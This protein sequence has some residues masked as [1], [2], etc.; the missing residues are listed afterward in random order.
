NLNKHDG[1]LNFC[2]LKKTQDKEEYKPRIDKIALDI[3]LKILFATNEGDLLGRQFYD[4]LSKY[5]GYITKL[6]SHRQ[7]Q[8]LPIRCMEYDLL[9]SNTRDYIKNE[10]HR[11]INRIVE[12]YSPRTIVV[13][14]LSF[15]SMNLSKRINRLLSMF[16]LGIIKK[17]LEALQ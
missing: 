9:V 14:N 1:S 4:V 8:G 10:I 12:I 2:L 16:G 3:G 6:A 11:C 7:S 13:E 5:D 17:K 15:T